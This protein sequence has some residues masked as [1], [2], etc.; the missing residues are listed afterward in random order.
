MRLIASIAKFLANE[1]AE[2][3]RAKR[4]ASKKRR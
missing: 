2:R 1:A 4:A 3:A